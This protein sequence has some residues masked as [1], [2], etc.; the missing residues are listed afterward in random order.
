MVDRFW[1]SNCRFLAYWREYATECS[2]DPFHVDVGREQLG[3][4]FGGIDMVHG[5]QVPAR[6]AHQAPRPRGGRPAGVVEPTM[7]FLYAPTI[8]VTAN[9]P[10]PAVFGNDARSWSPGVGTKPRATCSGADGARDVHLRSVSASRPRSG[11][12]SCTGRGR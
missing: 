11:S 2:C 1:G 8:T 6:R 10:S 4:S 9:F 7:N 3:E 5:A 12:G